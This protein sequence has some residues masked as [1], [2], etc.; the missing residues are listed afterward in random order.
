DVAKL[1]T[2]WRQIPVGI[3]GPISL[4]DAAKLG[5]PPQAV[6]IRLS[7]ARENYD[8]LT[9]LVAPRL[10]MGDRLI[11]IG[12]CLWIFACIVVFLVIKFV[13]RHELIWSLGLAVGV[14]TLIA[15]GA[16]LLSK[17]LLGIRARLQV[18]RLCQP[19]HRALAE[20][21]TLCTLG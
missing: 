21:E 18:K 12:I 13:L 15:A 7:E 6:T 10:L 11:Y 4:D 2:S 1:L 5:P 9:R 8:K 14:G 17:W 19:L 16:T 20:A 3:D